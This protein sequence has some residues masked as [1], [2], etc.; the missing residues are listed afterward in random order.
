MEQHDKLQPQFRLLVLLTSIG[1][2]MQGLDTTIIFTALPNIAE[3]LHENPLKIQGIIIGYILAVAAGIPVSGWIADKFGLRNTYFTAIFI[4]TIASLA[5]GLAQ[6]LNQLIFFRVL[7]GIGGAILMPIARLAL[8]KIIPRPQFV[9]AISTMNISGLLG[10]LAGPALGG[11]LV[12]SLSWHWIF[13]VNIPI[14]IIGMIFTLKVMPNLVE[15]KVKKFDFIGYFFLLTSMIGFV[16][17]IELIENKQFSILWSLGVFLIATAVAVGY[18]YHSKSHQHAI[19]QFDLFKNKQFNVGVLGMFFARLGSNAMPFLL[20]LVLQVVFNIEPMFAG[21]MM[22]PLVFGSLFSKSITRPLIQFFGYKRL[23]L[24]NTNLLALCI[25]SFTCITV[26]T[27]GWMGALLFF[28]FGVLNSLQFV[29][30]N[31]LTLRSLDS[32]F[33]SSGNSFLSMS[34]MLST[35]VGVALAGVLLNQFTVFYNGEPMLK[36]FHSTFLVLGIST[37]MTTLIFSKLKM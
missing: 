11:I 13:W 5:C 30:M 3:S 25:A 1:F 15:N 10:P 19:F 35:S 4:F 16:L 8:L 23:L 21:L 18:M 26:A 2:F 29:A 24:L 36:I 22:T 27:P 12:K 31:T 33:I 17:S 9:S 34:M 20:P 6:N 37:A 32:K 28:V 7:Q 14:G